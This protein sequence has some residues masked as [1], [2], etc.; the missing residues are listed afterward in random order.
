[1]KDLTKEERKEMLSNI[2][3]LREEMFKRLGEI[4]ALVEELGDHMITARMD[5]YWLPSIKGALGSE[6]YPNT[7]M[8]SLGDTIEEIEDELRGEDIEETEKK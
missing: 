5:A 7:I 3:M 8:Y 2:E 6:D 4:E 1:M